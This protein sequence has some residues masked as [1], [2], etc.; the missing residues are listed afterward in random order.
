MGKAE[1]AGANEVALG[2]GNLMDADR[3]GKE[4]SAEAAVVRGMQASLGVQSRKGPCR[5]LVT[6]ELDIHNNGSLG[7]KREK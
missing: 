6:W 5:Q 2:E 1:P 3:I 7:Q 4:T